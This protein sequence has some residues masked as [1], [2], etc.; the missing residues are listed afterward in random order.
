MVLVNEWVDRRARE[1]RP[2]SASNAP[3]RGKKKR[4]I[5]KLGFDPRTSGLWAQHASSAPLR[6]DVQRNK[7][8]V[9]CQL[10]DAMARRAV[11]EF[12]RQSKRKKRA[13]PSASICP[14]PL[15]RAM[16]PQAFPCT[17]RGQIHPN[18]YPDQFVLSRV[19]LEHLETQWALHAETM[20]MCGRICARLEVLP[21]LHAEG[22]R[23]LTVKRGDTANEEDAVATMKTKGLLSNPHLRPTRRIASL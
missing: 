13:R 15:L 21:R 22:D 10:Y 1:R 11:R 18:P 17:R 5:A 4:K 9:R 7:L 3:L 6:N 19:T 12:S 23:I 2:Q 20:A 8:V 14:A 16:L